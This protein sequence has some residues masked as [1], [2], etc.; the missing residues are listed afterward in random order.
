M[1]DGGGS[2]EGRRPRNT[3]ASVSARLL[4]LAHA[5]GEDYQLVLMRYGLERLLYRLG[6][7][8]HAAQFIVKGALLFTLWAHELERERL[9]ASPADDAPKTDLQHL[10]RATRD[11]DL[12]GVGSSD[13]R[14]LEQIFRELITAETNYNDGLTFL[15]ETVRATSIRLEQRYGG[16]RVHLLA[17]LGNARI[18][19]Q[20]DI[21]FG[22]IVTPSPLEVAFPT[23]LHDQPA[24][25]VCVYPREAVIAEKFEAL[26]SLGVPNTR[27]KDFYDLWMLA[28]HFS[29]EGRSLSAALRA[30]FARRGVTL[31]LEAPIALTAR[32]GADRA[33]R[34]QWTA[35]MRKG[36]LA[37]GEM[38]ELMHV[39]TTLEAFLMPPCRSVA[40]DEVFDAVWPAGGLWMKGSSPQAYY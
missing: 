30:T 22:D 13:S 17:L 2:R 19:L 39:L 12:L 34:A 1:S 9:D 40:L 8:S 33:K 28:H 20:I 38:P 29:F 6:H 18:P 7:S 11:L 14:R 24:P 37:P 25:Q 16:D 35:F 3:V 21:G 23:L 5:R 32:F 36:R 4:T 27:L 15:P 31:P 10:R 26:V